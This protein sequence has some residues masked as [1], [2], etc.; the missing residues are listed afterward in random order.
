MKI[1]KY[2]IIVSI[3][4]FLPVSSFS[5]LLEYLR[6]SLIAGDAQIKTDDTEDWVPASINTP[7]REGDRLWVPEEGKVEIQLRD[8]SLLR[9]DEST[10]LEIIT[11]DKDSCQFY[12]NEGRTYANF[13][14]YRGSALQIDTPASSVQA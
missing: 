9:L 8:G 6:I 4:F 14:E 11:V 5:S 13:K 1:L 2:A 3:L 10:A 12:L 7:L